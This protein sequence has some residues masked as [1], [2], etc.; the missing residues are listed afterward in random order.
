MQK[1]MK[2]IFY[3]FLIIFGL[4]SK[5]NGEKIDLKKIIFLD[6]NGEEFSLNNISSNIFLIVNTASFCGFTKQYSHLQ[7]LR[8]RYNLDQLF[9]IAIPSNDFG[10]QEPGSESEIKDFCEINYGITFPIMSKQKVL[11]TNKHYFY[12]L[13]EKN[14]GSKFLPKWNFHKYLIKNDGTL[15][16]S[17]SSHISPISDKFIRS[18]EEN[19]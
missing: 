9:I 14:Y 3:I 8:S 17:F 13:I 10:G 12:K 2:F 7:D 15:I 18:I 11:G 4:F 16:K 5:A 1:T 19:L 6:I